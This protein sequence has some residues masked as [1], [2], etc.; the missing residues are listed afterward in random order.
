M[1]TWMIYGLLAAVF[2][3]A[4]AVAMKVATGSG[5]Y[6]L[7]AHT[8]AILVLLGVAVVFV[9]Y[10]LYETNFQLSIAAENNAIVLAVLSGALWGIASVFLYKGFNLGADASKIVPLMNTSALVAV[11]IGIL[12]LHELPVHADLWRAVMGACLILVGA[13]MLG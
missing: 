2:L 11:V 6:N 5:H 1:E 10:Y 12:V 3:G 13:S 4:S 9:P 7:N 8:G